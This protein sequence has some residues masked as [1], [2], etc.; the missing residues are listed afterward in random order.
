MFSRVMDNISC[1]DMNNENMLRE[2][3]VKIILEKINIQ[4]GVEV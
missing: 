1:C 4:E 2:V 3:T